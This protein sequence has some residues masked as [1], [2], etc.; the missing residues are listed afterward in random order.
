MLDRLSHVWLFET[1]WTIACQAS[2]SM[3]FSKQEYS[4]GLPCPSP[5]HLPKPGVK[6]LSFSFLHWFSSVQFSCS[7]MSNSL[8]PHGLQH[9]RTPCP[10]PIPGAWS[11][12]C[13]LSQWWHPT[14]SSSAIAFSSSLQS[15]P[16][17]GSF[18]MSVLRIRWPKYWSFSFSIN[19][20]NEYSGLISFR[21]DWFDLL[22][23]RGTQE[24]SST[25]QLKIISSLAF[26]FLYRNWT[27]WSTTWEEGHRTVF[28]KT[29][30]CIRA[31]ADDGRNDSCRKVGGYLQKSSHL[32]S[33]RKCH[34]SRRLIYLSFP[35]IV[36]ASFYWTG[37]IN[38]PC[39][40]PTI[41]LE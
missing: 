14:I 27:E 39:P 8:R 10:S 11:N 31:C 17:S 23:V 38:N 16:A 33:E 2:L 34:Q 37:I 12:S 4:S 1:L 20:S 6:L 19:P 22:A 9:A 32:I 18:P 35:A 36:L 41:Q 28:F 40:T 15:F 13:P 26:S 3:G 29:M 5:R 24:S 30:K 25:L 7:V 21:I